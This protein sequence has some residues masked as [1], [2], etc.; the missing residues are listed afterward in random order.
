[1]F[2]V[3]RKWTP[4]KRPERQAI[5]LLILQDIV[6]HIPSFQGSEFSLPATVRDAEIL[7]AFSGSRISEYAQ[8][9]IPNGSKFQSV[10]INAAS[11]SKGG[12]P[13]AFI[14]QDFSF[15]YN[16]GIQLAITSP[17]ALCYLRIRFRYS[18]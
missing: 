16:T 2:D 9:K 13:I 1:M 4:S 3:A 12:K 14:L 6:N 17:V 10:P 7:S 11:G 5:T 18:K 8:R 15:L